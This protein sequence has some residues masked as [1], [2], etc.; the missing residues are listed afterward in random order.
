MLLLLL[1]LSDSLFGMV[2]FIPGQIGYLELIGMN[3]AT[4]G[5]VVLISVGVEAILDGTS[6]VEVESDIRNRL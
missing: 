3:L 6:V 1:L 2:V 4:D 5:A